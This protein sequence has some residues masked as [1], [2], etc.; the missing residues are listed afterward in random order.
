MCI[1]VFTNKTTFRTKQIHIR[2]CAK[3][4]TFAETENGDLVICV[5]VYSPTKSSFYTNGIF[6][7]RSCVDPL[8]RSVKL[9]IPGI[10]LAKVQRQ[11]NST[12]YFRHRLFGEFTFLAPLYILR[13][14]SRT[15]HWIH[16]AHKSASFRQKAELDSSMIELA[17]LVTFHVMSQTRV[18]GI[19]THFVVRRQ[20]M[21][22]VIVFIEVGAIT[23]TDA[24]QLRRMDRRM[25]R[26]YFVIT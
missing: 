13:I 4:K 23:H 8:S 2:W 18:K 19:L 20:I 11:V 22:R 14:F 5:F 16:V 6:M 26:K 9:L 7:W 1:C 10:F 12:W 3:E 24:I 15:F 25:D 21:H 17:N